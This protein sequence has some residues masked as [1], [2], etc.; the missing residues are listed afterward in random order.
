M[1]VSSGP[2]S[3][4]PP[5]LG[6]SGFTSWHLLHSSLAKSSRPVLG[7]PG[8]ST[9]FQPRGTPPARCSSSIEIG[10]GGFA[11]DAGADGAGWLCCAIAR[12]R[13]TPRT[14]TPLAI[15]RDAQRQ[16]RLIA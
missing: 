9:N 8:G 13:P 4:A 10:A 12:P 3:P 11:A 15:E 2:T 7:S 1:P 5:L 16:P 6:K 14:A